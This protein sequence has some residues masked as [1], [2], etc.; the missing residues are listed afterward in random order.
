M[1]IKFSTMAQ[2]I[3]LSIIWCFYIA[4]CILLF[5]LMYQQ[6]VKPAIICMWVCFIVI[7]LL[8][9]ALTIYCFG[10]YRVSGQRITKYWLGG[11]LSR[12]YYLSDFKYIGKCLRE[13]NSFNHFDVKYE[14]E[15]FNAYKSNN[16]F[17]LF[18]LYPKGKIPKRK[19]KNVLR[20]LYGVNPVSSPI[21]DTLA[22]IF[23]A[24]LLAYS[25]KIGDSKV[26]A[27]PY[28]KKLEYIV[29]NYR[30]GT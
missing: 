18:S 5:Y 16:I 6:N 9:S 30:S 22:P 29:K 14:G 28:S 3:V 2:K 1:K 12:R 21:S 10:Y 13:E 27:L 8:L 19:L 26:I 11:L 24:V 25:P 20:M 17:F 7:T 15:Y 23:I 4:L